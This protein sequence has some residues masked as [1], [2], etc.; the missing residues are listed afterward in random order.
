MDVNVSYVSLFLRLT[1]IFNGLPYELGR[2]SPVSEAHISLF[3]KQYRVTGEYQI[4]ELNLIHLQT[5][6]RLGTLEALLT[7]STHIPLHE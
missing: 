2:D 6:N 1:S 5:E 4:E 3:G 7:F